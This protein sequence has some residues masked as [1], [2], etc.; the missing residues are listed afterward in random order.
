MASR[1]SLSNVV[2]LLCGAGVLA[3][4]IILLASKKPWEVLAE[5]GAPEKT[6]HFVAI[7]SWWA[8]ACNAVLLVLLGST[9]SWWLR[10]LPSA[11]P[12]PWL[13]QVSTARWFWPL[14]VLAMLCTAVTGLKRINFSLWDD[15]ENSLRRVILGEYRSDAKGKYE[16]KEV[17]WEQSFWNYRKPTNHILQ[18][19]LS[20]ASVNAWRMVASPKGLQFEEWAVRLPNYLA[21]ILSISAIAVLLKRLGYARAGVL[22]AFLLA[23]HPWHIRYAVELRGYIF[24][25]LFLPLMMYALLQAIEKGRWRWWAVFG[26]V[27]FALLYAY[28]GCLYVLVAANLGG[29]I[30]LW[31]RH[32]NASDR[33]IYLPRLL[34]ASILSGMLYLQLMLPNIP[35]LAEYLQTERALG[36]LTARWHYNLASHL[37]T[38]L[39]WN[40]SDNPTAGY[41]EL[42]WLIQEQSWLKFGVVILP[43]FFF[44]I[45]A[46]RL[47][48]VR[49]A[50][51][52]V[53]FTML[54]PALAIYAQARAENQYLYEWYIIFVLPGLVACAALGADGL[55]KP[56]ERWKATRWAAPALLALVFGIYVAASQPARQWFLSQSL[57]SIRETVL[58]VRPSLDPNDPR[59]EGVMTVALNA[60]LKAYD[61]R[62]LGA[63]N[64]D[65]LLQIAREADAGNKPLYLIMSNELAASVDSP[66]LV[67]VLRDGQLFEKIRPFQGYDMTLTMTI[68]RYK[69]GAAGRFSTPR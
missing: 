14:V 38:G 59:Q 25:I 5:I 60:H 20:K 45:G 31:R 4:V 50:G 37:V 42:Q 64:L 19:L 23:L 68:W 66:E 17:L 32:D 7:Y 30:A 11:L 9:V 3:I 12:R 47:L 24:T 61:P 35:Q 51:W 48:F 55:V 26:L 10:P 21:G 1:I 46:A 18:T 53:I 62:A 67:K 41:P 22:A 65:N 56:L 8:W 49:P 28:T 39:P 29:L 6:R 52:L 69:P 40:N 44:L 58:A 15:E 27:Q 2:R 36:A 13:P 54:L 34:I 33:L 63:E 16:L 57:Q 43:A